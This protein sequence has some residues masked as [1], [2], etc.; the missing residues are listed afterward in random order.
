M[1]GQEEPHKA[2]PS[3]SGAEQVIAVQS[4][5]PWNSL[6][7]AKILTGG[8]LSFAV[9]LSG[10]LIAGGERKGEE[11][12]SREAVIAAISQHMQKVDLVF[13]ELVPVLA[14]PDAPDPQAF[15][16]MQRKLRELQIAEVAHTWSATRV[17]MGNN[18]ARF[19]TFYAPVLVARANYE[20]ALELRAAR[21]S[22]HHVD[23]SG[24][25]LL[26]C[27]R[28]F[29]RVLNVLWSTPNATDKALL[30]EYRD[31]PESA[32]PT[33]VDKLNGGFCPVRELL[34][35]VPELN[36]TLER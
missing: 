29:L 3:R 26:D 14:V 17:L 27:N 10:I 32:Q 33:L 23:T 2:H 16:N 9:G 25:E 6:E 11:D 5:S 22:L 8:L 1:D 7:I 20:N 28:G 12:R 31:Y 34:S 21:K 19:E 15:P 13:N 4:Q 36:Y 18:R 35:R 30:T 24:T